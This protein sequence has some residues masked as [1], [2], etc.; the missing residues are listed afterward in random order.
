[1]VFTV[2]SVCFSYN[3]APCISIAFTQIA[4]ANGRDP[5]FAL[6]LAQSRFFTNSTELQ[7]F[8]V[9]A[10]INVSWQNSK[11]TAV[12]KA[13]TNLARVNLASSIGI[14]DLQHSNSGTVK[15]QETSSSITLFASSLLIAMLSLLSVL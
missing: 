9:Q 6:N 5:V 15:E 13:E 1:M 12:I 3:N 14:S 11:R 8:I 7:S 4:A 2:S 10:T